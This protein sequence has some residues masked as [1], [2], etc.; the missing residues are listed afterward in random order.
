MKNIAQ[1]AEAKIVIIKIEEVDEEICLSI[2]DDGKGFST[3]CLEPKAGINN[4]LKRASS[5]NGQLQLVSEP[6]KGTT[7][8]VQIKNH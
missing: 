1:H 8:L 2:M 6:G 7:I 4:M 5:I 3:T